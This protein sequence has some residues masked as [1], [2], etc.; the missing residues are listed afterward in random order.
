MIVINDDFDATDSE[1]SILYDERYR[2]S[3]V[4]HL[5]HEYHDDS[6]WD[7][8]LKTGVKKVK[9]KRCKF[10]YEEFYRYMCKDHEQMVCPKCLPSHKMCD[11]EPMGA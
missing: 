8:D 9:Q 1:G 7:V 3:R 10:H 5:L 4:K 11:F 2:E 6:D